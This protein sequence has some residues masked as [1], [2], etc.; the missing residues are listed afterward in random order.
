M[1]SSCVLVLRLAF[2]KAKDETGPRKGG[3]GGEDARRRG[4]DA[5][6]R[7]RQA[8]NGRRDIVVVD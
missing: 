7:L 4:G 6:M 2:Q 1:V 8:P 5:R 3:T